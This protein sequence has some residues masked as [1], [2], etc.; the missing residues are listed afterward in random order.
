MARRH[1]TLSGATVEVR[2]GYGGQFDTF[3]AADVHGS[4]RVALGIRSLCVRVDPA[5]G[6]EA[7]PDRMLVESVGARVLLWREKAQLVAR[8]KPEQ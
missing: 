8:H 4:N 6:A 7:M 3:Q 1:R 2:D 5:I